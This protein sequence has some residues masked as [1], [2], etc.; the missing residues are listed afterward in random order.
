VVVTKA[1]V[2]IRRVINE[3]KE[4][5]QLE[6]RADNTYYEPMV[7]R[8]SD[9]LEIWYVRARISPFLPS[10]QGI[11][12]FVRDEVQELRKTLH[13]QS[14]MIENLNATIQQMLDERKS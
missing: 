4:Q 6:L 3:I 2:L 7:L 5:N 10:P 13:Q 8:F 11:K 12:N 14:R 1:N 9:I